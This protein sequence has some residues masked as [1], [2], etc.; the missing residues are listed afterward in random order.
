MEKTIVVSK[1]N[2]HLELILDPNKLVYID[3]DTYAD[4]LQNSF[5]KDLQEILCA[6]GTPYGFRS[7]P[8]LLMYTAPLLFDGLYFVKYLEDTNTI[9]MYKMEN[10]LM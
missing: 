5:N 8:H 1:N 7:Y 3:Y 10:P 9:V 6:I 4:R 2:K